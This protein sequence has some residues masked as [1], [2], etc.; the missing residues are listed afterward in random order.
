[1]SSSSN[2]MTNPYIGPRAFREGEKIY[3][4]QRETD[5]LVN[6]IIAE[7]IVLMFSPSGAGKTSLIQ[8]AL[9]P[10]LV[11]MKFHVLPIVRVNLDTSKSAAGNVSYNRY[12]LSA[13]LSLEE[14]LPAE[15]R[16][17]PD[18]LAKMRL[19]DYLARRDKPGNSLGVE[20]LIFDQFEEVLALDPTDQRAKSEFF[21]QLGEALDEPIR[22][23]CH[24]Q[25]V[26]RTHSGWIC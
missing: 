22:T 1:M 15:K 7:R 25:A 11:K 9:I 12:V 20:V 21:N 8:A 16:T 3:G 19:P 5:R 2:T 6:L 10:R 14:D 24:Y 17:S 26:S 4:R 18:E 13:L 23:C